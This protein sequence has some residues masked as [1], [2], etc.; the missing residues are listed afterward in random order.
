MHG[1]DKGA[2]HALYN[3]N[4]CAGMPHL[5]ELPLVG[6]E[7]HST[8]GF[9]ERKAQNANGY[10]SSRSFR[11]GKNRSS[12]WRNQLQRA[13]ARESPE[14]DAQQQYGRDVT[15]NPHKPLHFQ[16]HYK[17]RSASEYWQKYWPAHR[18]RAV[19]NSRQERGLR[20]DLR[21]LVL[22]GSA[23]QQQS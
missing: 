6:F 16:T 1:I 22:C 17:W 21:D 18:L 20:A 14:L 9:H 15:K 23:S 3:G 10:D 11:E 12:S 7:G 2:A 4:V 19:T 5:Y 8:S 13:S